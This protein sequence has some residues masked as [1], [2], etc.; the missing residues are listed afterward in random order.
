MLTLVI[1]PMFSG[2]TTYLLRFERSF[3][4][5]QKRVLLVKHEWDNRYSIKK[6]AAHSGET[7]SLDAVCTNKLLSIPDEVMNEHDVVLLDEGQFF[8]DLK[9]WCLRWSNT[10]H[11]FVAGLSGDFKQQPFQPILEVLSNA[12]RIVHLTSICYKCGD[13]APFSI[14]T[15]H[16]TQQ[17]VVGA[18]DKYKPCCRK[19]LLI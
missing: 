10:K 7:S 1:G 2:K 6:A 5:A 4:L 8:E 15:S 12:D 3:L 11:L 13:D 14:R 18:D 19:C 16:E 17:C 9:D